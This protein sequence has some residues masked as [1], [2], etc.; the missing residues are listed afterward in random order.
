M[1]HIKVM[2]VAVA[3]CVLV[4]ILAGCSDQTAVDTSQQTPAP[5]VAPTP[6]PKPLTMSQRIQQVVSN[7]GTAGDLKSTT[8]DAKTKSVVSTIYYA[9]FWDNG[10][11]KTMIKSDCFTFLK[12]LY[13]SNLTSAFNDAKVVVTSNLTDA[14]GKASVG[15]VGT[16]ELFAS[17]AKKFN[18]DNLYQDTAWSVYDNAWYLPS[19][20]S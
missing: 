9:Q 1:K 19:L 17:T 3:L 16:C 4:V 18:W 11:A 7:A 10:T 20:D 2:F 8:Y 13:T 12:A 6:T 15:P 14:Y 5:T